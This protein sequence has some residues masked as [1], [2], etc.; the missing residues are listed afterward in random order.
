VEELD[1][2]VGGDAK[3]WHWTSNAAREIFADRV[4]L[5]GYP[6][7]FFSYHS[8]R[9]GFLCSALLKAANGDQVESILDHTA[10]VAGWKPKGNA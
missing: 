7:G 8:L 4:F 9:A 3:V 6:K 10:F 2:R 5:S 1:G